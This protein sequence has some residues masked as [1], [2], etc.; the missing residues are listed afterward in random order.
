MAKETYASSIINDIPELI[1][2]IKEITTADDIDLEKYNECRAQVNAGIIMAVFGAEILE[3]K[4]GY[5]LKFNKK[6]A[7]MEELAEL[8]GYL[9][10]L[11]ELENDIQTDDDIP[12]AT[13]AAVQQLMP[14]KLSGKALTNYLL[15]GPQAISRL[16]IGPSEVFILASLSEKYRK[17]RRNKIILIS[18]ITAAAIAA[19]VTTTC[20]ILSNKKKDEVLDDAAIDEDAV[21]DDDVISEDDPTPHVDIDM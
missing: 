8:A 9:K 17:H 2:D 7:T 15:T 13:Q 11:T 6:P 18:V 4:N 20:I 10:E 3:T 12:G 14:D 19:G 16:V 1:K 5:A 21:D